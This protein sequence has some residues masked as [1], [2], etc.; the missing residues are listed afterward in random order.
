MRCRSMARFLLELS[1]L[2]SKSSPFLL[3]VAVADGCLASPPVMV[4]PRPSAF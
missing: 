2:V 4:I 3:L 1:I